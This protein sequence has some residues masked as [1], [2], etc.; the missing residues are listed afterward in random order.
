MQ[1]ILGRKMLRELGRSWLRYLALA[2]V[3]TLS[4]Y[5]IVSLLG[6]ADTVLIGTAEHQEQNRLEDGQFTVFV[7]LTA[8]ETELLETCGLKLEKMFYLDYTLPDGSILRV[9]RLRR[10]MDL[11]EVETGRLPAAENQIALEKRYSEEHALAPGEG[12]AQPDQPV[13]IIRLAVHDVGLDRLFL[14][15]LRLIAELVPHAE[16]GVRHTDPCRLIPALLH[17]VLIT[18]TDMCRNIHNPDPS[19][20]IM[21]QSENICFFRIHRRNFFGNHSGRNPH[22]D[23][24]PHPGARIQFL[25]KLLS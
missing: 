21:Q 13:V 19:A 20:D 22:I 4:M 23:R 18:F 9:F 12:V 1:R 15:G 24:M 14:L 7:P 17:T 11:A 2:L 5:L 16:I 10:E 3:I 8:R 25:R 6:A